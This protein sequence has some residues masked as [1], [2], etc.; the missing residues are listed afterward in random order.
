L[1]R[2]HTKTT[3]TT[4]T[5]TTT[6]TTTTT[7][8]ATNYDNDDNPMLFT[9]KYA[10][11]DDMHLSD[12][13]LGAIT[14]LLCCI[15][16]RNQ[17]VWITKKEMKDRLIHCGVANSLE[18]M[19]VDEAM[20]KFQGMQLLDRRKYKTQIYF[21][22]NT[23]FKGS[24]KD[25]RTELHPMLPAKNYFKKKKKSMQWKQLAVINK[26]L[27]RVHRVREGVRNGDILGK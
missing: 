19:D 16:A 24:P 4:T 8:T 27:N 13:A 25:E 6:T 12:D 10:T 20:R 21:R 1:S 5:K 2:N 22:P 11:S 18:Q 7:T 26:D 23:F 14:H 9:R 17:E 15:P 3:T